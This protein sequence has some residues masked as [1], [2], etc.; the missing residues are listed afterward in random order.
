MNQFKGKISNIETSGS[1]SLV[2][3]EAGELFF[4]SVIIDT[5]DTLPQLRIGKP[6]EVVFKESE[7]IIAKA[8]FEI[9]LQNRIPGTISNIEMGVLLSK[10]TLQTS[11]GSLTALITTNA[12]RQLNLKTEEDVLALVKTNEVMLAYD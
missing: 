2:K 11:L 9:S 3:V 4:T 7:V 12:V 8:P 6:V 10:V 5:P 1:L